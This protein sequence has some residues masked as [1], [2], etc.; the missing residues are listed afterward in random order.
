ME[1]WDGTIHPQLFQPPYFIDERS[2]VIISN[3]FVR[4]L[5][6][7]VV[8]SVYGSVVLGSGSGDGG[9]EERLNI[10][11][12]MRNII[13]SVITSKMDAKTN[14]IE[15]GSTD[16]DDDDD[17]DDDADADADADDAD[18]DDADDAADDDDDGDD[19]DDDDDADAGD[20][21]DDDDEWWMMNDEWWMMNDE[22]WMM[23]DEWCRG[24]P[25]LHDVAWW[26]DDPWI[27]WQGRSPSSEPFRLHHQQ[28]KAG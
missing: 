8:H 17:D 10:G 21:D 2:Y 25:W 28:C 4:R 7:H 6:E 15:G 16:D 14:T 18:A 11:R 20:D 23:N 3:I 19:D 26:M 22:W 5:L 27:S 9:H 12:I 13:A 1:I 24:C